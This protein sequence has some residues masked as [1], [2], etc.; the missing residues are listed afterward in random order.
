MRTA[1]EAAKVRAM[2]SKKEE[3]DRGTGDDKQQAPSVYG[4]DQITTV[5]I[6]HKQAP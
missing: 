6:P 3:D 1:E 2:V 5:S 4:S